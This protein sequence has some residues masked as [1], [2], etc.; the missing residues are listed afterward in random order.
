MI[1]PRYVRS[2]LPNSCVVGCLAMVTGQTFDQTLRGM[3]E[4]WQ[5]SGQ[6]EGVGDDMFEAYLCQRGYA[7]QY[8]HH[9]YTPTFTLRTI[10]PPE[11]FAPIHVCDVFDEGMHAIVM[12]EDGT[13][14]D[15][16]DRKRRRLADYHRVFS[17]CGIWK[18]TH[19]LVVPQ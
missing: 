2:K 11:P 1:K 17:V 4:Y 18:V 5:E 19:P 9:E 12:L 8:I 6:F 13:I 14:M 3:T 7:L 16:N 15:P 10:W